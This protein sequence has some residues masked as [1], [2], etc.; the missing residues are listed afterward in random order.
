MARYFLSNTLLTKEI[1]YIIII[2]MTINM[3]LG[4]IDETLA[5]QVS[6]IAHKR[7]LKIKRAY[8]DIINQY[9]DEPAPRVYDDEALKETKKRAKLKALEQDTPA[10]TIYHNAMKSYIEQYRD[11]LDDEPPA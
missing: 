5:H 10:Y 11:L 6:I 3:Y 9:L 1:Q 2:Y 7:G 4:R 8:I